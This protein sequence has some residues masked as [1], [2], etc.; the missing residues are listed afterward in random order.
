MAIW[1]RWSTALLLTFLLGGCAGASVIRFG[2]PREGVTRHGGRAQDTAGPGP[3][4]WVRVTA[5]QYEDDKHPFGFAFGTRLGYA[6]GGMEA[7]VV[8][9]GTAFDAYAS[10]PI[11]FS[12]FAVVPSIGLLWQQFGLEENIRLTYGGYPVELDVAVRLAS[13]LAVYGGGGKVLGDTLT[14]AVGRPLIGGLGRLYYE[15]GAWRLKAGTLLTVKDDSPEWTLRLE[16]QWIRGA[17]GVL[18]FPDGSF[19]ADRQRSIDRG[20]DAG[21]PVQFNALGLSAELNFTLF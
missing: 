15:P 14:V 8:N 18:S 2:P 12:R 3:G 10:F 5:I 1:L 20:Y 16:L 13:R 7:G 9:G 6:R 19:Q 11:G 21:R 4:N 17:Q